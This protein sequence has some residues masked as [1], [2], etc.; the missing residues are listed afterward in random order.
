[1]KK[2]DGVILT[3]LPD[4]SPHP[5]SAADARFRHAFYRRWGRENCVVSGV[6]RHAEYGQFRQMLSVK[7][8]ARGTEEYFV[9]R[10]RITVSDET[11]LVLNEGRTYGSLLS[12]PQPSYS[13]A[14]FFRPG[15]AAEIAGGL[16]R[17]ADQSLDDGAVERAAPL[18]FA[19]TLR[20]HD[21][22]VSPVLRFMQREIAAGVRD[23]NW[24][25]EQCQFLVAR[26]IRARR[27]H[28]AA[29]GDPSAPRGTRREILR[30]L[31]LAIDFMH[32]NLAHDITLESIAA[33]ANLS[34][35]HFLRLFTRAH[36]C[37]PFAYLRGLRT[38]RALALLESTTGCA[39]GIAR[40]VGMTRHALWRSL[41]E[42]TGAGA[43]L[44]RR[45]ADGRARAA[46]LA[47]SDGLSS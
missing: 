34:R 28:T 6:A 47:A 32:A 13:F 38:R 45:D 7:C 43:R 11:Y 14:I 9:E 36:G 41:C 46:F 20:C 4:L 29:N 42:L 37:T 12:A 33:A 15:L 3:E 30:R 2:D 1:M 22:L 25:E 26:L 24:L 39:H 31:Q 19:E 5:L 40:Q 18:E 21:S 35:F 27:A 23:E 44:R 16:A 17:T 10:R 8:V